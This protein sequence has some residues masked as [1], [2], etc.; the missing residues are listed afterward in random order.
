MSFTLH[1][2]LRN[3]PNSNPSKQHLY[4][5][6]PSTFICDKRIVI[7]VSKKILRPTHASSGFYSP[8]PHDPYPPLI[9]Q[10]G[11][12]NINKIEFYAEQ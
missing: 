3:N 5:P 7:T 10:K 4:V 9:K 12:V 6:F 8:S 2:E 11:S 1:I